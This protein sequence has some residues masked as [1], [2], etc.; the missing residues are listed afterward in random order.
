MERLQEMSEA[1]SGGQSAIYFEELVVHL[2]KMV[3]DQERYDRQLLF[4]QLVSI[5]WRCY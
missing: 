4:S 2:Q 1:V 3:N 5:N